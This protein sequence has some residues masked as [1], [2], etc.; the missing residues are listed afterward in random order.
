L[1]YRLKSTN[2]EQLQSNECLSARY[3]I[4]PDFVFNSRVGAIKDETS[5][6]DEIFE[7]AKRC[8]KLSGADADK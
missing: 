2:Y 4:K 5:A 7:P 8:K 6:K 1:Q 3:L